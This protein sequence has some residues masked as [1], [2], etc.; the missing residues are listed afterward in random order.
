MVKLRT[1]LLMVKGVGKETADSILLYA[2]G[3][4]TFVVDAYTIRLCERFPINAGKGYDAAKAYFETNLPRCAE[5]Y[6]NF[7]AM[8]V[9]NG[10]DYCKKKPVCDSCPL[11]NLCRRAKS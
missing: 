9:I 5:V 3:F 4:P 1:E 2:F 7:H 6:N 11:V 8:I 10:K